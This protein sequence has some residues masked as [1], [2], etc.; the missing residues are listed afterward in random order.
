VIVLDASVLIAHLDAQD[1]HH[2][3][4]DQLLAETSPQPLGASPITLAEVLVA[5]ARTGRL[6][7]ANAALK[8]LGVAPIA[9]VDDASL[10]LAVLRAGT[11]LR[12]P[13][14]CVLLAAETAD[15]SIATF[16]D[17]LASAAA[18]RGHV[19]LGQE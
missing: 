4:A 12:L 16:D 8:R 19:V 7:R 13:D 3:R 1:A 11:N 6:D 9:L 5:P 10:R 14:C 17:R 18:E 15:A 2:A